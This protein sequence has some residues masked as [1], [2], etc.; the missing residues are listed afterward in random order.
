[1]TDTHIV[2]QSSLAWGGQL[3]VEPSIGHGGTE[4]DRVPRWIGPRAP[5][6]TR[7]SGRGHVMRL[8]CAT[9]LAVIT[10][11][12]AIALAAPGAVAEVYEP[13]TDS[14]VFRNQSTYGEPFVAN[15]ATKLVGTRFL[16][17]A[18]PSSTRLIPRC[19]PPGHA[20]TDA[21]SNPCSSRDDRSGGVE[22]SCAY[23]SSAETYGHYSPCP[24][25]RRPGDDQDRCRYGDSAKTDGYQS[26]CPLPGDPPRG[27]SGECRYGDRIKTD[28]GYNLCPSPEHPRGGGQDECPH[29]D[30]AKS[31][32]HLQGDNVVR[33]VVPDLVGRTVD[34][35]LG[36]LR[37]AG[38]VLGNDPAD[39]RRVERQ[40]PA[41]GTLVCPGSVVTV[42]VS[43][44]PATLPVPRVIPRVDPP[45]PPVPRVVYPAPRVVPPVSPPL[46]P[47][48]P[49]DSPVPPVPAVNPPVPPVVP[50]VPLVDSQVLPLRFSEL[51]PWSWLVVALILL[52]V[53]LVTALAGRAL[54]GQRW[55]RAHVRAVAGVA[56]SVGVEVME[57]RSDSSST[58]CVVRMEPHADSGMQVLE[59]VHQ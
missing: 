42:V 24:P 37:V 53:G 5:I 47:V 26:P 59:E 21:H 11:C 49:V 6:S 8:L 48:P 20:G 16:A 25:R 29:G 1:M 22:S 27:G 38:L 54:H 51:I 41:A 44:E 34:G 19:S 18:S 23:A 56:P 33:V 52:G 46:S 58:T 40:K 45:V 14:V 13:S 7:P 35:A 10:A 31:H 30:S 57:S 9:P 15:P 17:A 50:S 43:E 12:A 55:V 4:V 39:G 32:R 3:R 2:P 36:A 28:G